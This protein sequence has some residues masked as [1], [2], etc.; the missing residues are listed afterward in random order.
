MVLGGSIGSGHR[1]GGGV[2]EIDGDECTGSIH[3]VVPNLCH[4]DKRCEVDGSE[5]FT[6]I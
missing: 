4:I 3:K 2:G 1:N 5:G 6:L